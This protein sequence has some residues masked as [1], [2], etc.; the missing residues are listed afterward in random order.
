[1]PEFTWQNPDL[2]FPVRCE[3]P[4]DGEDHSYVLYGSGGCS[5]VDTAKARALGGFDEIYEPAYVEDLDF[6]VRAWQRGWP[7]VF[8]SGAKVTHDHRATTSRYYTEQ[9]LERVLEI[10]YL[11]FLVRCIQSPEVFARLWKQAIGRLNRHAGYGNAPA[12]AALL[13]ARHAS[14]WLNRRTATRV[15]EERLLALASGAVAVFPG[16]P[17]RDR[18][19]ILIAAPYLPFPLAHGGAVRMYNLMRRASAEY[20]QVLI[21][22]CDEL[23]T[24]PRELLDICTEIVQVRRVGSHVL[25]CTPRPDVVE[26]F[27]SAAFRE[28]LRQTVRKWKPAVAQL[29][30]TQMAQ[31]SRECEPAKTVLVEH[32]ITLDLY[33]QLL[34]DSEDWET[35]RQ[36]ERW[37]TFETAAWK[38]MD[39]VVTMSEKDRHIVTN[40]RRCVDLANGVDLDRFQPSAAEP[41]SARLLFIG[42]FGHL[43]NLLALKFF[44]NEIW[45]LI[46]GLRP[47]LH[48]IA[49]ARH[50]YFQ[51][52]HQSRVVVNLAQPGIEVED[53]VSD[54]RPAYRRASVVIA[55]LLASAGTNIKIMEAMAMGKA[56]VS[57]PGGVNGLSVESGC[58]LLVAGTPQEFANAVM[59]LIRN[60]GER[61]KMEASGRLTAERKYNWDV[62]AAK[63]AELYR[64]LRA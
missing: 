30:F 46:E 24:P 55:P 2:P 3:V 47:T 10:N 43:P 19:V 18:D 12:M 9:E 51:Q 38:E 49:G 45:P 62:I 8:V 53:F 13:E 39:C 37:R 35:R 36:W 52:V 54:V 11:R 57:T 58:D 40:A 56:I 14:N 15:D 29:E 31:Y 4:L 50:E 28:A 20:D 16:R 17:Q 34:A 6:G 64:S 41:E 22:F 21:T 60:P 44:L 7:T 1:M 5:L 59:H 61:K 32:D 23:R 27:D 25:P 42:S 33:Q 48:I 26:E 63:Q